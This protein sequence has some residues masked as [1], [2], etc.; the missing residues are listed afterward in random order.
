MTR[1]S[2]QDILQYAFHDESLLL[3][4][5]THSSYANEMTRDPTNGNER[6]EFLGDAILDAVV[7]GFLYDKFP[8]KE[9]GQLTKLR[10]QIV[11]EKS[12]GSAGKALGIN[13]FIRLGKGEDLGGGRERVSIV[14][15]AVEAVIGAVFIDGGLESAQ[16]VVF[17]I[18]SDVL[19]EVLSGRFVEDYK[20]AL[21]ELLQKNGSK[22]LRYKVLFEEGPDH[23][24]IFSTA[25]YSRSDMHWDRPRNKQKR[26]GA[27]CCP[28]RS[29]Q[30]GVKGVANV[31]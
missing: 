12:L 23:A 5:L 28:G 18:L 30:Y 3:T 1:N 31:F 17:R 26:G 11:C 24:K 2:V 4:A 7:S 27:G 20:T 9:E 14:A 29:C 6:L 16:S 10:A 15:D 21:Q 8:E 13:E 25:V 22:N 19:E